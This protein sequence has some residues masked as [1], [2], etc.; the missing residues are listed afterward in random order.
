[1]TASERA[2][3]NTD[4][5][6]SRGHHQRRCDTTRIMPALAVPTCGRSP[7]SHTDHAACV[8][9]FCTRRGSHERNH[10]HETHE[11]QRV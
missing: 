3:G 7:R 2:A 4:R 6:D 8:G 10:G 9:T 5:A 1:M 11:D